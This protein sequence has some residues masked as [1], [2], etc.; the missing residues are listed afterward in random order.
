MRHNVYAQ[1]APAVRRRSDD[2]SPEQNERLC[3]AATLLL[4][5]ASSVLAALFV[6]QHA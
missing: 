4:C 5:V 6:V 2:L 1:S 3:M